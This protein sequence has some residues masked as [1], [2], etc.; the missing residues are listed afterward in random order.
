MAASGGPGLKGSAIL[1]GTTCTEG[2]RSPFLVVVFSQSFALTRQGATGGRRCPS[3]AMK[4]PPSFNHLVGEREQGRRNGKAEGLCRL[5]VDDE[6]VFSRLDNRKIGRLW[7]P[8][9]PAR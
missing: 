8:R 6:L 4:F 1:K 9:R 7:T 2:Q 5:E 3:P